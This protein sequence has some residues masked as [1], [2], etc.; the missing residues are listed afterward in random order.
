MLQNDETL[1]ALG[2]DPQ[3]DAWADWEQSGHEWRVQAESLLLPEKIRNECRWLEMDR[4]LEEVFVGAGVAIGRN[5]HLARL[6]WHGHWVLSQPPGFARQRRGWPMLSE[7]YGEPGRM[8]YALVCLSCVE[9]ARQRHAR[10]GI[11]EA[12]TKQ[13]LSDLSIWV[14]HYHQEQGAWGFSQLFWLTGHLIGELYQLG[15]L[16]FQM[17]RFPHDFHLFRSVEEG[18]VILLAGEGMRFRGD[19]QFDGAEGIVDP[20]GAWVATYSAEEDI[21]RGYPITEQGA[22]RR[23]L[24]S[25]DARRW[26]PALSQGDPILEVHIQAGEPMD[27]V[28]CDESFHQARRFFPTHFPEHPFKALTCESWLMDSQ[29][30]QRLAEES[31]IVHF[32]WRFQRYPLAQAND[33]QIMERVFGWAKV[34]WRQAPQKTTLQRCIIS[35]LQA[36]GR[37]R[38]AGGIIAR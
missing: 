5:E 33:H 16:Q 29:L 20:A 14:R 38:D 11:D 34:D 27:R 8:M 37:W 31:N 32:L 21:V 13:T 36:G 10:R 23:E 1:K 24:I 19:G 7:Q 12:L 2:L 6:F 25:L 18:R 35:H 17:G 30:E 26:K 9:Q 28:A 3:E 22:A 15:R 4:E